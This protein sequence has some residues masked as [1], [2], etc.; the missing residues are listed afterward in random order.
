MKEA[1]KYNGL[2]VCVEVNRE[3]ENVGIYADGMDYEY[4][5]TAFDW[6]RLWM[7]E[8]EHEGRD[9]AIGFRIPFYLKKLGLRDVDVRMNDKI[10]LITKDMEE[11]GY[12]RK[13]LAEFR[14]WNQKKGQ[15]DS[16]GLIPF[17]MS[18]GY[19]RSEIEDLIRFQ[20]KM[21]EYMNSEQDEFGIFQ[22]FVFV[23]SFGRK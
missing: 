5:C 17:M 10:T 3:L 7:K 14:S 19:K 12:Y 21:T 1:V 13:A 16:S 4:L 2:V 22:Y 15:Q 23:I 18:R 6:R 8:L 11:F 9:Y 20:E